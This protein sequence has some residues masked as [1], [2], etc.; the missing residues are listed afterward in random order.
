MS[1]SQF[2]AGLIGPVFLAIGTFIALRRGSFAEFTRAAVGDRPLIF[3]AG[4]LLLIAGIAILQTHNIWAGDW[5][6]I[7]TIFGWLSIVGG[8]VRIFLPEFATTIADR[9]KPDHPAVLVMAVVCIALGA[10]LTAK[11]HALI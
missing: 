9:I 5:R 4:I 2:I 7:I 3:L 8:L 10:F 11:A 1:T 6:V